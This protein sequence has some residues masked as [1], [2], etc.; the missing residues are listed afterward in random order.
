MTAQSQPLPDLDSP[1]DRQLAGEI[2]RAMQHRPLMSRLGRVGAK[3]ADAT[4]FVE[5]TT[6]RLAAEPRP[7]PPLRP[8]SPVPA[9]SM[10]ELIDDLGNST[11]MPPC[12]AWLERARFEQRAARKRNALAWLTTFAIVGAITLVAHAFIGG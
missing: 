10:E 11:T 8:A 9:I 12:A 5:Q 1:E 4:A 3:H 2:A 7:A 6:R